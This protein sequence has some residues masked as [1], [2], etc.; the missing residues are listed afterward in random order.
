[1]RKSENKTSHE[2]E[3][4]GVKKFSSKML[5]ILLVYEEEYLNF[6]DL[7]SC[8]SGVVK[9]LLQEFKDIFL[10]EIPK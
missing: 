8:V 6:N 3:N 1:M 4:K 5:M 10:D 7:K 2:L 9:Y